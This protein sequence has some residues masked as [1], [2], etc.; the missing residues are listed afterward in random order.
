MHD[1]LSEQI[2]IEVS[3]TSA[4]FL[5]ATLKTFSKESLKSKILRRLRIRS[6]SEKNGGRKKAEAASPQVIENFR[7]VA[8]DHTAGDR[9][10][11]L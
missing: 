8:K 9:M 2:I 11:G 6:A 5:D 7:Q 4:S 3:L 1:Q 10:R